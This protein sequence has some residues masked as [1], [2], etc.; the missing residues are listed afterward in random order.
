MLPSMLIRLPSVLLTADKRAICVRLTIVVKPRYPSAAEL[1]EPLLDA[2]QHHRF[3]TNAYPLQTPNVTASFGS[4]DLSTSRQAIEAAHFANDTGLR[5]KRISARPV[6]A[7]GGLFGFTVCAQWLVP[8]SVALFALARALS[9]CAWTP[10]SLPS[11]WSLRHPLLR[12]FRP[13]CR[14][15]TS[16]SSGEPN[17]HAEKRFAPK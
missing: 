13:G 5:Q 17:A 11:F 14:Q 3:E 15:Q 4:I 7:G 2:F 12:R 9:F 10:I 8:T 1:R 16:R 6:P